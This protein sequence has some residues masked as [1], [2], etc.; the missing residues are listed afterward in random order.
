MFDIGMSE[1]L[2]IGVVALIVVGPQDLPKM[3]RTLGRFTAKARH[4]AGEFSRAMEDAAR[5][6]GVKD[7]ADDLKGVGSKKSLGLDALE[8]AADRFEKWE[9]TKNL[10]G[11]RAEALAQQAAQQAAQQGSGPGQTQLKPVL[12]DGAANID[13][14]RPD[15]ALQP[16]PD[17]PAAAPAPAPAAA[18]APAPAAVQAASDTP[19]PAS[20]PA[21]G[22]S[23][24]K[25]AG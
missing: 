24:G 7:I 13:A 12:R 23:E 21:P 2:V 14:A 17:A 10:P 1:L 18:P 8:R 16:D 5:E 9:P 19:N 3:F 15:T 11:S 20:A 6:T 22:P 25:T 4:M